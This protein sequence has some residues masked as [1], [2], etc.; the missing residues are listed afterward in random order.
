MKLSLS[1]ETPGKQKTLPK[2]NEQQIVGLLAFHQV[3]KFLFY[4]YNKKITANF[5]TL[6]FLYKMKLSQ[7]A[8]TGDQNVASSGGVVNFFS[9]NVIKN[10]TRLKNFFIMIIIHIILLLNQQISYDLF[11]SKVHA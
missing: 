11:S 2:I 7:L 9:P 1:K 4:N 6:L 10:D 8:K 3:Y 5:R